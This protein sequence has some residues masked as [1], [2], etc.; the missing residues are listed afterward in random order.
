MVAVHKGTDDLR[1]MFRDSIERTGKKSATLISDGANNFHD[2]YRKEFWSPYGEEPS[3]VHI[4]DVR[5]DGSV[6]NNKMERQNG[7]WGMEGQG[8]G[9]P[10]AQEGGLA[11]IAGMQI[12]HNFIRPIWA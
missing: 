7:E 2:A 6:Q 1:P 5:F 12:Y 8:E 11:A 9:H 10:F 3:L 4:R